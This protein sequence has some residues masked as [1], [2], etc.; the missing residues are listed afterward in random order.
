MWKTARKRKNWKTDKTGKMK[1]WKT[2]KNV[3]IC[4]GV[5]VGYMA[6]IRI[7]SLED[8]FGTV[9]TVGHVVIT[10]CVMAQK[11]AVLM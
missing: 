5:F 9:Q 2:A 8:V 6:A 4:T 1:I 7:N 11:G 10:R 3:G